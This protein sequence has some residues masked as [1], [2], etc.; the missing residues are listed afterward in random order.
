MIFQDN[1]IGNMLTGLLTFPQPYY[2]PVVGIITRRRIQLGQPLPAKAG[3][4]SVEAC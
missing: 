3:S 4:L 1:G 2:L